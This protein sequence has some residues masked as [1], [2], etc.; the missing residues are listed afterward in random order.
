MKAKQQR[1]ATWV[2]VVSAALL[3]LIVA[4]GCKTSGTAMMTE[5][6]KCP[7]CHMQTRTTPIEGLTIKKHVCPGCR[8]VRQVG[9]WDEKADLTE[10]HVCDH[11]QA[12]VSKCPKCAKM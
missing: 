1:F 12:V 5:D 9:V 2:S 4:S 11:C 10:V 3:V 7:M 8:T 6:A